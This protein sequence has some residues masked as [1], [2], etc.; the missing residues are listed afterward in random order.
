MNAA[1]KH[2]E[3]AIAINP[4]FAEAYY[5]LGLLLKDEGAHAD[6]LANFKKAVSLNG[7]FAEAQC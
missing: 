5:K 2:L 7:D 1:R 6:A 3:E 4:N